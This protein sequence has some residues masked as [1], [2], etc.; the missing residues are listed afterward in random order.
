MTVL[1]KLKFI[2]IARTFFRQTTWRAGIKRPTDN[3][4]MSMIVFNI[5]NF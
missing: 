5:P 3:I 2:A 1:E 4:Y